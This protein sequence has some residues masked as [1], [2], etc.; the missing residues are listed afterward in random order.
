MQNRA[1]DLYDE[2]ESYVMIGRP[3]QLIIFANWKGWKHIFEQ[4]GRTEVCQKRRL[5]GLQYN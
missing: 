4:I 2:C 3:K 5:E 1:L